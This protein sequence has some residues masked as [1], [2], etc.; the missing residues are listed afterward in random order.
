MDR[1][2]VREHGADAPAQDH[3]LPDRG[4]GRELDEAR[5]RRSCDEQREREL[6]DRAEDR[7]DRG[8]PEPQSGL[9]PDRESVRGSDE[10]ES[11]A[12]DDRPEHDGL[13]V[14]ASGDDRDRRYVS[15]EPDQQPEHHVG[16]DDASG[17]VAGV[18]NLA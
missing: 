15:D 7:R 14:A 1:Q 6:C 18:E 5:A 12:R 2:V 11:E 8:R 9:E 3:E 16:A 13:V 17:V 4:G 10:Q